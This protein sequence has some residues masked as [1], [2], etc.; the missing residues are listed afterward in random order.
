MIQ[1]KNRVLLIA[2]VDVESVPTESEDDSANAVVLHG[3]AAE[4][5]GEKLEKVVMFQKIQELKKK[6]LKLH[7]SV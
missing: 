4:A 2:Q 6:R 7:S 1:E 3:A 5:K